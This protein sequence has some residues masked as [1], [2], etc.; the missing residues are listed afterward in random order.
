[1]APRLCSIHSATQSDRVTNE[2]GAHTLAGF[3]RETCRDDV[4]V[5]L[6]GALSA[7]ASDRR[8]GPAE[9]ASGPIAGR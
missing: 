7:G 6:C 8:W 4:P 9:P 5:A 3:P 2:S 1:M